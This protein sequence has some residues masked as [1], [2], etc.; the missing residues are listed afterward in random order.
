[1]RI[2]ITL[3]L[4]GASLVAFAQT[5]S[6]TPRLRIISDRGVL[7]ADFA[8]QEAACYKKFMV[9]D[10]LDEAML[11]RS[12]G[13]VNLRRQES[14]LNDL[15][16]KGKGAAQ[17]QKIDDK[18]SLEKQQE[19]AD[20]LS[21]AFKQ[22]QAGGERQLHEELTRAAAQSKANRQTDAAVRIKNNLEKADIR[23]S[24]QAEVDAQTK[25]YN[26]RLAKAQ[27]RQTRRALDNA[28]Q[29]KLAAQPLP[30]P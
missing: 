6:D 22:S 18:A 7:E 17:V 26:D 5:S 29:A 13:L 8:V 4:L 14:L 15:E 2:H 9:N 20:R 3:L 27:E 25:K 16:R 10:C 30:V 24:K 12:N 23:A 11:K 21:D 28:S 1:M 19:E